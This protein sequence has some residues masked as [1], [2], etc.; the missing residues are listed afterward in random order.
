MSTCPQNS[1]PEPASLDI[2]HDINAG[3][4]P[5]SNASEAAMAICCAPNPVHVAQNCTLWCELPDDFMKGLSKGD[6][7]STALISCLKRTDVNGSSIRTT[8]GQRSSAQ[9]ASATSLTSIVCA[10]NFLFLLLRLLPCLLHVPARGVGTAPALGTFPAALSSCLLH[11]QAAVKMSRNQDG[12]EVVGGSFWR[13]NRVAGGSIQAGQPGIKLEVPPNGT[14]GSRRVHLF[15]AATPRTERGRGLSSTVIHCSPLQTRPLAPGERYTGVELGDPQPS[16]RLT[17]GHAP[18]DASPHSAK[19]C[20]AAVKGR[21]EWILGSVPSAFSPSTLFPCLF[22]FSRTKHQVNT[23]RLLLEPSN[24]RFS[25]IASSC[26]TTVLSVPVHHSPA[27]AAHDGPDG[28][29]ACDCDR[30]RPRPSPSHANRL[31]ALRLREQRTE[32]PTAGEQSKAEQK[33]PNGAGTVCL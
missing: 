16:R 22:L 1:I 28:L 23:I 17:N 4:T 33:C 15:R 19:A 2:P 11:L 21:P 27:A 8:A 20:P 7:I 13:W 26:T 6:D 5:K 14:Y 18:T 31:H 24:A 30:D 9:R 25:P 12:V 32:Q 10:L 3:F 29:E